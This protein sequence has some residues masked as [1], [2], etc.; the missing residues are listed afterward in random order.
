MIGS[1]AVSLETRNVELKAAVKESLRIADEATDFTDGFYGIPGMSGQ[2]YRRFINHL[3]GALEHPS[4]LEVGLWAGSTLCSAIAR[5][6]VRAVGVDNWQ[7]VLTAGGQFK[8]APKVQF[9]QNLNWT[10]EVSP[11]AAVT[12]VHEDYHEVDYA[13]LGK[14]DVFLFD[15]PHSAAEQQDGIRLALS[16][17]AE[18][19]VLIVDDWNWP[20]VREGTRAAIRDCDLSLGFAKEIRTNWDGNYS[21]NQVLD[22]WHNGVFIGV[23]RQ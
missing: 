19:F 12:I 21:Q 4:Y 8:P 7:G 9:Y 3:I 10:L 23:M 11:D 13:D 5:N 16:A 17:L 2:R 14:F 20:E 6:H 18:E 1:S 15:G 22:P